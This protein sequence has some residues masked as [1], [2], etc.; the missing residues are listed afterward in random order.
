[1]EQPLPGLFNGGAISVGL[2]KILSNWKMHKLMILIELNNNELPYY[3]KKW[4]I[5]LYS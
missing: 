1:L 3:S 2:F 5:L 4:Y